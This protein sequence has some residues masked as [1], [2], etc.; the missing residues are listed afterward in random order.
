[1]FKSKEETKPVEETALTD[2]NA[3]VN[4]IRDLTGENL[5]PVNVKVPIIRLDGKEGGFYKST[6]EVDEE[7]KMMWDDVG[8]EVSGAIIKVRKK[9]NTAQD[10]S[11]NYYSPEFDSMDDLVTLYDVDGSREP[12]D[13]SD[14]KTLKEKYP[15]LKL[16]EVIYLLENAED[17]ENRKVYR[18]IVKG[19]S[20]MNLW[21]YLKT[22]GSK[23][24]CLRY[25]TSF[26]FQEVKSDK[27]FKYCQ[28]TFKR[29]DVLDNWASIANELKKMN[30]ELSQRQE[31]KLEQLEDKSEVLD[32]DKIPF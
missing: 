9:L 8:K 11:Y 6:D 20:L 21:N 31:K 14:Y 25:T 30:M 2:F 16:N 12:V 7:G 3:D 5:A 22:F 13:Q 23:D 15:D 1:M 24:S 27:G 19:G 29:G 17:E 18:L 10:A 26:G 28:L 32:T 4:Q